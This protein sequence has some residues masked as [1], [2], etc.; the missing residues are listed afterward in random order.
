MTRNGALAANN[1]QNN[2]QNLFLE[3]RLVPQCPVC[4]FA[5]IGNSRRLFEYRLAHEDPKPVIPASQ[6]CAGCARAR[7]R[8]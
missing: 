4:W 6:V 8:Q 2:L 5:S 1:L 7:S 3:I